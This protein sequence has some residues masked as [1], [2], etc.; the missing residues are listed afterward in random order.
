[1][2]SEERGSGNNGLADARSA[3]VTRLLAQVEDVR[4]EAARAHEET[5]RLQ[6]QVDQRSAS[7]GELPATRLR[8]PSTHASSRRLIPAERP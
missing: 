7:P 6:A 2:L 1:M 5:R 4:A 3:E 8:A